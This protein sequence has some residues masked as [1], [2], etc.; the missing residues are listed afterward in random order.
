M[1]RKSLGKGLDA[2][3][4]S[5]QV[6]G[7]PKPTAAD[8]NK[9]R[10]EIKK[11]AGKDIAWDSAEETQRLEV[12]ETI[13]TKAWGDGEISEDERVIIEGI[14]QQLEITDKE[15]KEIE[16]FILAQRKVMRDIERRM[17]PS[18]ADELS[19]ELI[20]CPKCAHEIEV[21]FTEEPK[22][23]VKCPGC[24]A[25]GRIPNPFTAKKKEKAKI[26]EVKEPEIR[27]GKR[28]E[29]MGPDTMEF[30]CPHCANAFETK[31]TEFPQNIPC[32]QCEKGV[33]IIKPITFECPNCSKKF[34][35]VIL[36][37][38]K[39]MDCPFCKNQIKLRK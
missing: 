10:M 18:K 36:G 3:I 21:K 33:K 20:N 15:H 25:K 24:G 8:R 35:T 32:P 29:D 13:L 26:P 34:P 30:R 19:V 38:E 11:R 28:V 31:P 6:P 2:L 4:K 17:K 14:R 27:Y 16:D 9:L 37:E 5:D 39:E 7:A 1:G 22:V 23:R 12:Y